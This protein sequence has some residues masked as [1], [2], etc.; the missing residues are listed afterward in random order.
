MTDKKDHCCCKEQGR[1]QECDC[2]EKHVTSQSKE[3]CH[4]NGTGPCHE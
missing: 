3:N 4:C 1:E 2:K